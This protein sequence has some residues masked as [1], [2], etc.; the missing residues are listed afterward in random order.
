MCVVFS[1][2]HGAASAFLFE[3]EGGDS[4]L[5]FISSRARG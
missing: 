1:F 4:D 2:A 3:V 5:A